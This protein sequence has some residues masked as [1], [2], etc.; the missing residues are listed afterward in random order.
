MHRNFQCEMIDWAGVRQGDRTHA[1]DERL[2]KAI[3]ER[4]ADKRFAPKDWNGD[5]QSY[6]RDRVWINKKRYKEYESKHRLE[7]CKHRDVL[8]KLVPHLDMVWKN[9][10]SAIEKQYVLGRMANLKT[11]YKCP[12]LF[13]TLDSEDWDDLYLL[14]DLFISCAQGSLE[15][16]DFPIRIVTHKDINNKHPKR[17]IYQYGDDLLTIPHLLGQSKSI[18]ISSR[19]MCQMAAYFKLFFY[20]STQHPN[21]YFASRKSPDDLG[22]R[23]LRRHGL[24]VAQIK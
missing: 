4:V 19:E 1:R 10:T 15:N 18:H 24:V 2:A 14:N 8:S 6:C 13:Y 12:N 20:R 16:T 3:V 22:E 23:K 9:A 17:G 11:Y 7:L 21:I 5:V